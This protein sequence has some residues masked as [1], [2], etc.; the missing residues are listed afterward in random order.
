MFFFSRAIYSKSIK[1]T[2]L[3]LSEIQYYA[4]SYFKNKN[5]I[6]QIYATC[7]L[8]VRRKLLFFYFIFLIPV[9][10]K[11]SN[12]QPQKTWLST[13]HL[14]RSVTDLKERREPRRVEFVSSGHGRRSGDNKWQTRCTQLS[15]VIW[16]PNTIR[17]CRFGHGDLGG[18]PVRVLPMIH[19]HTRV[20][21]EKIL[22]NN[23]ISEPDRRRRT[24]A[25]CFSYLSGSSS[26]RKRTAYSFA[27]RR[28]TCEGRRNN[29]T[30]SGRLLLR[31]QRRGGGNMYE[32][33]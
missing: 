33:V 32:G 20:R 21:E 18:P 7:M 10:L 12:Q 4:W 2:S 31:A 16:I 28:N 22:N 9:Y 24:N 1:I 27:D 29:W 14:K 11:I 17:L 5:K 23:N 8:M 30:A 15:P 3:K 26:R 13:S 6:G 25:N 19:M